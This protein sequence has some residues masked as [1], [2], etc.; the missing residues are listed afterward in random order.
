MALPTL[1][2]VHGGG[3][4]ADCWEPTV[5]EI[6]RQAPDLK[7]LAVD[8]PGR[9]GKPGDLLKMT[10]ADFVDSVVGDIEEAGLDEIVLVGHSMAG[11]TVPGVLTKLGS[12]R[13]RE[14]ILATAFVPPRGQDPRRHADGTVRAAR[15]ARSPERRSWGDARRAG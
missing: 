5:E 6:H 11:L 3:H 10:I 13:V 1:V 9:R 7:V 4:A 8:L 15:A 14:L 2:L 12:T